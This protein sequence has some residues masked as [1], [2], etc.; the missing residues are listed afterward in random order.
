M[1][2]TARERLLLERVAQAPAPLAMSDYFLLLNPRPV[3]GEE[4]SAWVQ[5]ELGWHAV[6]ARLLDNDLVF[7]TTPA[8]GSHPDLVQVTATGR[9][10]LAE[11]R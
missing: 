4:D 2:L 1:T 9:A 8:D 11:Q 7:V 3:S 5:R 6:A 10:A